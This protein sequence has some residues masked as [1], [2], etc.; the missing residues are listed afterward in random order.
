V[1]EYLVTTLLQISTQRWKITKIGEN[2]RKED[3]DKSLRLTF[4]GPLCIV[5]SHLHA[6]RHMQPKL[7]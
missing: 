7:R 3:M 1:V 6:K 5:S 4:L 2:F